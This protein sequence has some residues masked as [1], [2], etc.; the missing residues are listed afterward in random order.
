MEV[1]IWTAKLNK[2]K[3]AA[4]LTAVVV[5][6]AGL[7]VAV[8]LLSQPASATAE[9]KAKGIKT[10]EDRVAYLEGW[11]WQ[12]SPEATLV[13]ELALPKEFGEEYMQYLELQTSQ[14][15]DLAKYAGKRVKRYTYE[16]L[17]HPSGES[18]VVAHLLLYKNT[19]VGGELMGSDFLTGLGGT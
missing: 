14:G 11:G 8:G 16:I 15:F 9:P 2:K 19:V 18:G 3:L 1:F 7:V 6:G 13:E 12:V 10:A 4:A 17:N 5:A